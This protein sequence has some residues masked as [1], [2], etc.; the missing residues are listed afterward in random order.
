MRVRRLTS[1]GGVVLCLTGCPATD[2]GTP[3]QSPD[4]GVPDRDG[5]A[6][7]AQTADA[8]AAGSVD[9]T[10]GEQGK[11]LTLIPGCPTGM[12]V[13]P[14]GR[15]LISATAEGTA[16]ARLTAGGMLD[17]TFGAA[18]TAALPTVASVHLVPATNL[19][20]LDDGRIML[21]ATAMPQMGASYIALLRYLPD[22]TL[23][24]SF[25]E[26]GVRRLKLDPMATH[27]ALAIAVWSGPAGPRLVI[28]GLPDSAEGGVGPLVI[29]TDVDGQIRP[30]RR[31]AGGWCIRSRHVSA[32]GARL[33]WLQRRTARC[34]SPAV[35]SPATRRTT[36][37][38]FASPPTARWTVILG[39]AAR[40]P[41][42]FVTGSTTTPRQSPCRATARYSSAV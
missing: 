36:S 16:V 20:R 17:P 31:A 15:L 27:R 3:T 25:G 42:S 37:L 10:F 24:V 8:A 12:V 28:T 7:G 14:D 39:A 32:P 33:G 35:C 19:V 26:A 11:V 23:D 4:S 40:R 41:P 13:L 30:S 2:N 5:A 1:I 22:G 34:S 29:R 18:G 21:A 6:P 38:C 9:P